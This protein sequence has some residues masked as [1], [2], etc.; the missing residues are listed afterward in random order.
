MKKLGL[1]EV[2]CQGQ[3]LVVLP[4]EQDPMSHGLYPHSGPV[5]NNLAVHLDSAREFWKN[6]KAWAPPSMTSKES[7]CGERAW[8][9]GCF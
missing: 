8:E 2:K 7:I 9:S 4:Q 5:V 6:L 3:D 1:K